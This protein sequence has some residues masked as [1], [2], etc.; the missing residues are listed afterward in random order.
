MGTP[1]RLLLL[2]DTPTDAELIIRQ[3]QR[4][5]FDPDWARVETREEYLDE[6]EKRPDVVLADYSLPEF[7]APE[8]LQLLQERGYDIPFIVVSG[9]I[10]EEAAV[11]CMKEGATDYIQKDRMA[12][13]GQAVSRALEERQLRLERLEA[14]RRLRE[15]QRRFETL[16][17]MANDA[18]FLQKV[19]KGSQPGPFLEVNDL[20]CRRLGYPREELLNL[21]PG[22]LQEG[23]KTLSA[24]AM[25]QLKR[26][27][28]VAYETV[29]VAKNGERIPFEVS[30]H[31]FELDGQPVLLSIGRDITE[32]KRAV[33]LLLGSEEKY[34]RLFEESLDVIFRMTPE[35]NLLDIN[36]AGVE[37]FGYPNKESLLTS[38]P[39][40]ELFED[41]ALLRHLLSLCKKRGAVKN[42]EV[43]LRR[44]DGSR[45]NALMSIRAAYNP[46]GGLIELRGV[47]RDVT[48]LR[49]LETHLMRSE[50]LDSLGRLVSGIAHDFNN[51]LGAL[52]GHLEL[53]ELPPED[54]GNR[55]PLEAARATLEQAA[56]LTR[57]MLG[58][59]RGEP[60]Q[61]TA[62]DL[63]DLVRD[64]LLV[65]S[66]RLERN[67]QLV[68]RFA[69]D[70]PLLSAD[71]DQL[72]QVIMNLAINALDAMPDGGTL[73]LTTELA[74]LSGQPLR[75][76]EDAP[77]GF[78][79]LLRIA[80]TGIGM[81]EAILAKAFEPFFSTKGPGEG[82]G[83]G[84]AMVYSV[85]KRHRGFINVISEPG[86]GAEFLVYLPVDAEAQPEEV[87]P[88]GGLATG[89]L[90]MA[91]V[92][93]HDELATA[94]VTMTMQSVGYDV[95]AVA[96][97]ISALEYCSERRDDVKLVVL[98][99]LL[100]DLDIEESLAKLKE[101]C[102]DAV[103]LVATEEAEGELA[104][105][106][107]ASGASGIVSK[108]YEPDEL[109]A[110]ARR[111]LKSD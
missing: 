62:V 45:I 9:K 47:L 100:V 30:A 79:A 5:G 86:Q 10:G 34:R 81:S 83:L 99:D 101:L 37:L 61:L 38:N 33:N 17:N 98:S 28:R 109:V 49:Q 3:L 39:A 71:Q 31:L 110:K 65:L 111:I 77:E 94:L 59:A 67:I 51:L 107:V 53:I 84:L 50:K 68:T 14:E 92:V 21:D 88:E 11:Q 75:Q 25:E 91:L 18:M 7:E 78:F 8:A 40:E 69:D 60:P 2:E 15:S 12:R 20:A 80:D 48:E 46:E 95:L 76:A 70:L 66:P 29:F 106:L 23:P 16:F 90:G 102:P 64:T 58:F 43:T 52:R 44:A 41:A 54:A 108:P 63:N 73:T 26:S 85:V 35:G 24:A 96:D 82:T 36:R 74:Q 97:P 55:Q 104:Q 89:A 87:Q 56:G 1:L 27:K 93:E 6:L 57:Q 19:M 32:R 22:E 42:S 72:A 4:G 13:L 105:R 103:I